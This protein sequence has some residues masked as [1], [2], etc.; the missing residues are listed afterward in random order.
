MERIWA[1]ESDRRS[2]EFSLYWLLIVQLWASCLISQN[3]SCL[4]D[5]CFEAD[6]KQGMQRTL[7]LNE[8]RVEWS[9]N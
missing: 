4:I 3:L 6:V 2:Y 1:L 9:L 7:L 8:W 5:N